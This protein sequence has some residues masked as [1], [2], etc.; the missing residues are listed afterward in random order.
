MTDRLQG[1][2]D[3]DSGGMSF[4]H[5]LVGVWIQLPAHDNVRS[6]CPG[7]FGWE[8]WPI[9]DIIGPMEAWW[10]ISDSS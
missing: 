2:K 10:G 5:Y 3:I 9:C 4:V 1:R 6:P 7:C 8:L